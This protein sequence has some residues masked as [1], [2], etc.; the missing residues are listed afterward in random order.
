MRFL[1][2]AVLA[3]W[4]LASCAEKPLENR[5]AVYGFTDQPFEERK[6]VWVYADLGSPATDIFL[7]R[8][9]KF[10]Q[11]GIWGQRWVF[12]VKGDASSPIVNEGTFF[13]P[14]RSV[15]FT[16]ADN[17]NQNIPPL[18]YGDK[19]PPLPPSSYAPRPRIVPVPPPLTE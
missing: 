6:A 14:W 4:G 18:F 10:Y 15:R 9:A 5:K 16:V 19:M 2:L 7:F 17:P 12:Q 3:V 13:L 1:P 11:A 8:E